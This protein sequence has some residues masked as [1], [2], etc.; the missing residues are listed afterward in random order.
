VL[1]ACALGA[2][3]FVVLL[4]P[5]LTRGWLLA[6]PWLNLGCLATASACVAV[7]WRRFIAD[8]D[9]LGA[10]LVRAVVIPYGGCLVFLTLLAAVFWGRALLDGEPMTVHDTASLYV[11]GVSAAAVSFFV[12]IPYGLLCQYVMS[13]ASRAE[14]R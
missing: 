2:G 10:H 12:V 5:G 13:A 11:S 3:W 6:D 9:T 8:A 1:T 7:A 14:A 4:I